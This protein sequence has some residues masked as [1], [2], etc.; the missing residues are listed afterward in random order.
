MALEGDGHE[1]FFDRTDLAGGENYHSVIR[2][3]IEGAGL[4]VFLITP[5]SVREGSYALSELRI[6]RERWPHPKGH[7]LPVLLEPTAMEEIPAYLR[8]V[9]ILEPEGVVA[10]EVAAEVASRRQRRRRSLALSTTAMVA[11]TAAVVGW[12]VLRDDGG[13]SDRQ[14]VSKIEPST[15]VGRYVFP[16]GMV[17]RS[18]L[19]LDSTA[20]FPVDGEDIVRLERIAF[21]YLDLPDPASAFELD[22]VLKNTTESPIQLD[23]TPRFFELVDDH[24]RKAELL[25]FCCE[26]RGELLDPTR[27]RHIQ[28]IYRSPPVWEGKGIPA[29]MIHLRVSG[30]LPVLQGTWSFAPL[31]T[32]E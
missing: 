26:A 14:F 10:A 11:L 19:T 32:A 7:V 15:F 9:T 30:L 31:A 25:Y 24:G 20:P 17:H 1:V 6:A 23:V 5:D 27:E 16:P 28:L 3:N 21:G 8:G 4:V 12:L 13:A 18:E 29:Q 2:E 22:L